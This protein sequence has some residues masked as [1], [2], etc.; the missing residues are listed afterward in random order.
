MWPG[1]YLLGKQQ[2]SSKGQKGAAQSQGLDRSPATAY[3]HSIQAIVAHVHAQE[4]TPAGTA[5]KVLDDDI[6]VDKCAASQFG[7]FQARCFPAFRQ[8]Y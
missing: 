2:T 8:M 4:Y 5:T 6:L 7:K 1:A 3:L